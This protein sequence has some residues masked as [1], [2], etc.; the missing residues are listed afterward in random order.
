MM[1]ADDARDQE[2]TRRL[3]ATSAATDASTASKRRRPV[4]QLLLAGVVSVALL[5]ILL[6]RLDVAKF[7]TLIR[8]ADPS[9]LALG[10]GLLFI[11][12]IFRAL[13][14]RQ[15]DPHRQP[16]L[17]WWIL[18]QIYNL[19]TSSLPGGAGEAVTA[20]L[21]RRTTRSDLLESLQVLIITRVMDLAALTGLMLAA[22]VVVPGLATSHVGAVALLVGGGLFALALAILI[23]GVQ[24]VCFALV[25]GLYPRRFWLAGT[26]HGIL[27]RLSDGAHYGGP[28]NALGVAVN[29][30]LVQGLAAAATYCM[31]LGLGARLGFWE[32]TFCFGIFILFQL[33][34]VQG[35]A[36]LGTQDASWALALQAAGYHGSDPIALGFLL[37]ATTF[38]SIAAAGAL[39]GVV[40]LITG[41]A[42]GAEA[43]TRASATGAAIR[44][45][46][47][48]AP[49]M[50][51]AGQDLADQ[52]TARLRAAPGTLPPWQVADQP[53]MPLPALDGQEALK[54]FTLPP[55]R[56]DRG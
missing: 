16:L 45:T 51:Q 26:V 35:I 10:A 47:R 19:M 52:P 22:A 53:T 56:A 37:H 7:T 4:R 23:P 13:R 44:G 3:V 41:P 31:V 18:T 8:A 38:L 27:D 50:P 54:P 55:R 40:W 33:V 48:S 34:P 29:T 24:R 42:G 46:A 43:S 20:V 17:Q 11:A 5:A 39:A 6:W 2:G 12:N 14:F 15:L 32:S 21:L 49:Q 1:K 30:L 28:L 25:R 9:L 36:G